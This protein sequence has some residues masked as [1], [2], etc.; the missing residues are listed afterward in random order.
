MEEWL[1][2]GKTMGL[3]GGSAMAHQLILTAKQMGF[4]VV[5]YCTDKQEAVVKAAD[6]AIIGSYTNKEA[7]TEL[8]FR[9]DFLVYETED[10]SPELVAF[11]KKTVPVPQGENLLSIVQ[12][13]VLQKAYLEANSINIAPYATIID[14]GDIKRAVSS[15]GFPCVLKTNRTDKQYNEYIV[16]YGEED[17]QQTDH[18]LNKGVC[19]LEALIPYER[20]LVVTV[21]RNR[22]GEQITFPV[23]EM[24]YKN[25]QVHQVITPARIEEEIED[26]VVRMARALSQQ[27]DVI[28]SLSLELFVTAAGTVYVHTL[29]F[30]PHI[31]AAST[32]DFASLSHVEAHLR[33]I[34]NWPLSE[35]ELY[36]DCVMVPFHQVHFEKVSRQIP[37]RPDWTF[38]F[39][40]NAQ[41]KF[42]ERETGFV[43]IP[44]QDLNQTLDMLADIDLWG[45]TAE[46]D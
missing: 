24:G 5:V 33:G 39:Y 27:L 40:P 34:A 31:S 43:N 22:A 8:A 4:Q 42:R 23:S 37:I 30:G 7:L 45:G 2:P 44:T 21:T 14:K 16:L 20:E 46:H 12:D 1:V 28:G 32:T 17:I 9:C 11:L 18:L 38:H 25:D 29:V 3:I 13:R 10:I 19:V 36:T 41:N 35:P 26:E 6:W 15:I